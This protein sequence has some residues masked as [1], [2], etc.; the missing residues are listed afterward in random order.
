M[1]FSADETTDIGYESGTTVT[2]DYTAR[3]QPLHRQDPLGAD[4][5]RQR[6]PRPLHR[7]RGAPPHR[8]GP[9]VGGPAQAAARVI[10]RP[11]EDGSRP[12][13]VR[14]STAWCAYGHLMLGLLL[15]SPVAM[16]FLLLGLDRWEQRMSA[17][18]LPEQDV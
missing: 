7:P 10:R 6:R 2:P 12:Q 1:I 18:D 16:L 8:H 3:D 13:R 11:A 9:A 5:P 17:D 4:R 15:L 14:L